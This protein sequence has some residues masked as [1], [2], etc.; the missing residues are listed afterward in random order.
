[1]VNNLNQKHEDSDKGEDGE[2]HCSPDVCTK[3]KNIITAN[4]FT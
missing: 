1:M 4:Y 3:A 2:N